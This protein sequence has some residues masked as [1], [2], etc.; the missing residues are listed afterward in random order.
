MSDI[1]HFDR[2]VETFRKDLIP[3]I[4]GNKIEFYASALKMQTELPKRTS[5]NAQYYNI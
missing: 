5:T 3:L 4:S 2:Y 1:I